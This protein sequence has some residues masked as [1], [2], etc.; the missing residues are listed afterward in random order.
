MSCS[1]AIA[2][3]PMIAYADSIVYG[4]FAAHASVSSLLQRDSTLPPEE[5]ENEQFLTSLTSGM[6]VSNHLGNTGG[7]YP[8]ITNAASLARTEYSTGFTFSCFS[9]L[10]TGASGPETY[11]NAVNVVE[12][13]QRF[14]VVA[15]PGEPISCFFDFGAGAYTYATYG[16]DVNP[17]HVRG[18][19]VRLTTG[20]GQVL[21]NE[22]HASAGLTLFSG[23]VE[24]PAMQ[25][26]APGEYRVRISSWAAW[27]ATA[28]NGRGWSQPSVSFVAG[29]VPHP[30]TL[31]IVGFGLCMAPR[32]RRP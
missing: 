25:P 17:T 31:L 27:E 3:M 7:T 21:V 30:G 1:L 14:T 9:R 24:T 13:E 11:L 8:Y 28:Q 10:W 5:A 16:P 4:D 23:R 15:G 22:S 32:H 20:D 18:I 19:E 29:L 12:M 2:A 6:W 26:L